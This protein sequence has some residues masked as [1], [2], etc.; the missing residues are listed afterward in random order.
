MTR[1][2]PRTAL[3]VS[4]LLGAASTAGAQETASSCSSG[5]ASFG[6]LGISGFSCDCT[7]DRREG[8]ASWTFRGEPIVTEIMEDGPA[9]GKLREGDVI[10]AI[11]GQ[12]ITT[13][14]AGE[15]V[16]RLHEGQRVVLTIRRNGR[17]SDVAIQTGDDCPA[18]T[19]PVAVATPASPPST[20]TPPAGRPRQPRPPV[21]TT[22]E[23][24][25]ATPPAP[26]APPSWFGFGISCHNCTVR[27]TRSGG[28]WDF[29]EFPTVYS[30]DPGSPA[31]DAGL[32]RGDVLMSIDGTS[33]LEPEGARRFAQIEPGQMVTWTI[34]RGGS[35]RSARMT[36]VETPGHADL[37]E[38]REV[39][40]ELQVARERE[41]EVGMSRLRA[42]LARAERE[43]AVG[44]R[45]D[46]SAARAMVDSLQAAQSHLA[47]EH[48]RLLRETL[49]TTERELVVGRPLP[50]AG[51]EQHLRF[52]GM[53]GNTNVEVRGLSSVDVS[54]DNATGEL[55]IRTMDSTIRV[56]A[57]AR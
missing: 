32:R 39:L 41:L 31:D 56:K 24:P 57:P 5:W 38:A 17:V 51:D 35:T 7:I 10:V 49:A 22:V 19:T 18:P 20:T 28:L 52:A 9:S 54:Y 15:K 42:D 37:S 27:P 30:V 34:R 16:A 13:R 1:L 8:G 4:L 45:E 26:P 53:V 3:V 33:L 48:L 55:L 21:A 6:A 40:E 36:A 11:D 43:V 25:R 12:L 50:T 14:S 2:A 23:V 29:S 47:D 44:S 46:L